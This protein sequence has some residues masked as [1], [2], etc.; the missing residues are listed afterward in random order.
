M[1]T[2][3]GRNLCY[4]VFFTVQ[5]FSSYLFLQIHRIHNFI[6]TTFQKKSIIEIQFDSFVFLNGVELRTTASLLCP[7]VRLIFSASYIL[8]LNLINFY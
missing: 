4:T 8:S 6:F 1:Q 3:E 7:K 5:Q 2:T